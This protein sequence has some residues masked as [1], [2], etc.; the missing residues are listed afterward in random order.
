MFWTFGQIVVDREAGKA[1][2]ERIRETMQRI[3]KEEER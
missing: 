1:E 3:A 2:R